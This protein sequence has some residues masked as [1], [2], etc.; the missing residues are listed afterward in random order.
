MTPSAPRTAPMPRPSASPNSSRRR[1]RGFCSRKKSNTSK[2]PWKI[3]CARSSPFSAA[4]KF[5]GKSASSK[6]SAS[7]WTKSSSAAAWPLRFSKPRGWRSAIRWLKT[8]CS[9]LPRASKI[10]PFHAASNSICRS[11]ASSPPAA[12]PA[13]NR[14]LSPCRRS[15][16]AGIALDIGPASV[17]LF[18]EAVAKCQNDPLERTDGHV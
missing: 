1:P 12:S 4:P 2:A 16:R 6:I 5:R 18:T 10:M 8:I 3:L 7:A 14:K 17:K 11:I 15:P 9:I 13:P